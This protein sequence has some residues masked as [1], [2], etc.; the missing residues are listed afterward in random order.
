[1]NIKKPVHPKI[2]FL[3]FL[4]NINMNYFDLFKEDFQNSNDLKDFLDEKCPWFS[5]NLEKELD[6]KFLNNSS[7]DECKRQMYRNYSRLGTRRLAQI[8]PHLEAF[9]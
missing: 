1:M 7:W 3:D 9:L 8:Y 5:P 4:K 6:R 2:I